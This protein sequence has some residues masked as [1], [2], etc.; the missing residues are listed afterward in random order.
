[1]KRLCLT[2]VL[3]SG[4]CWAQN[5]PPA[6]PS[7][8]SQSVEAVSDASRKWVGQASDLIQ[9]A[10]DHLGTPYRRGGASDNGF[11]CSGFVQSMYANTLGLLLPRSAVDQ[12]R[13]TAPI[14]ESEL[15][16]GDL[17]FF[18]TMKRAYS[19]VGIY[20]GDNEF[21]HSPRPGKKVKVERMTDRYWSQRFN[22]A[23]RVLGEPSGTDPSQ[24]P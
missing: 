12:A 4:A 6:S 22:G 14:D 2:V 5:T 7:I 19:H 3:M 8:W 13:A 23:R 10:M 24:R 16:P 21:I 11:D 9:G 20:L 18:N 17:V 1:M 15:K